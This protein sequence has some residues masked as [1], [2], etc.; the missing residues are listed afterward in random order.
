ADGRRLH[1]L[2]AGDRVRIRMIYEAGPLG[3]AAHG[4][5]RLRVSPFWQWDPPQPFDPDAPGYTEVAVTETGPHPELA[6][7]RESR[8]LAMRFSSQPLAPRERI[9]L[10]YGAGPALAGVDIYAEQGERL[11]FSVDGDG[12]G[13]HA[14][15][16]DSPQVDIAAGPAALLRVVVPT[17]ARPGERVPVHVSVLDR[18]GNTGVPFTGEVRLSAPPGLELPK[19]LRFTAPQQGR[20]T[21]EARAASAGI[22]RATAS[23]SPEQIPGGAR[24]QSNP[25][26]VEPG[27]PHLYWA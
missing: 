19:A 20:Q 12:D 7:D 8:T 17:T 16:A 21:V 25:L 9:Y 27:A 23:V 10:T 1:A 24:E 6:F 15:L 11:W 14:I 2:H 26:I 5:L 22:F 4:S 3:I 13:V 18:H